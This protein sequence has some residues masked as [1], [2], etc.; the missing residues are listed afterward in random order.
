MLVERLRLGMMELTAVERTR[1]R[2]NTARLFRDRLEGSLSCPTLVFTSK[3]DHFTAPF[4]GLAVAQRCGDG[5]F[6]MIERGDHLVP[7]ESPK[8]VL[9]LYDAFLN[10]TPL[11]DVTGVTVGAPAAAACQER[12]MLERRPGRRRD[13]TVSTQAGEQQRAQLLDYNAHGCLLEMA[14]FP[15]PTDA[16]EPVHVAIPSIG[17]QGD[18]V[19][20][21]ATQGARA[22]FLHDAFGS[23]GRIPVE[24]VEM[25][26]PDLPGVGKRRPSLAE[27]LVSLPDE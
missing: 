26:V 5:A 12:R 22:V 9:A 21:P 8:T 25:P 3:Y 7:V 10:D 24:T 14:R 6:A 11:T 15:R 19:L 17:A 27:R 2:D 23:L 20:L 13:V 4:K 18:A 1:Y 16:H